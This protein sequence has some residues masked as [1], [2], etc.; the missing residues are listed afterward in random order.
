VFDKSGQGVAGP[1]LAWAPDSKWIVA[2]VPTE[3]QAL[4]LFLIS[5]ETGEKR[6]LTNPRASTDMAPAFSPDGHTL[7]FTRGTPA[8]R[9]NAGG[10]LSVMVRCCGNRKYRLLL[11]YPHVIQNPAVNG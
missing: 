1:C 2:P 10:E 8:R 6:R 11:I 5:V 4:A 9:S 3:Q 7:A